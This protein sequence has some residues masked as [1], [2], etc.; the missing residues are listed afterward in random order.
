GLKDRSLPVVVLGASAAVAAFA[1][2]GLFLA[3][4]EQALGNQGLGL[5]RAGSTLLRHWAFLLASLGRPGAR[6][7]GCC[8]KN[9]QR[10]AWEWASRCR[11]GLTRRAGSGAGRRAAGR[12]GPDRSKGRRRPGP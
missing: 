3:A 7:I 12:G 6:I 1:C 9:V 5:V 10:L 11:A 2:L 4:A 8:A